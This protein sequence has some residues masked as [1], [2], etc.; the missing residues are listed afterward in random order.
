MTKAKEAP[1][2]S[3]NKEEREERLQLLRNYVAQAPSFQREEIRLFKGDWKY[4]LEI[5]RP[6]I[7]YIPVAKSASA[8]LIYFNNEF[9]SLPV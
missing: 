4:L 3:L 9:H 2:D 8:D 5:V 6:G 1:L 7:L